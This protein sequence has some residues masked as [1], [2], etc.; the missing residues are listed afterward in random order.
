MLFNGNIKLVLKVEV[1]KLI[2]T[3]QGNY[4]DRDK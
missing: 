2:I 4:H 1:S 3:I